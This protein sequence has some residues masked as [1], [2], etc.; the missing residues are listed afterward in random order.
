MR[1]G[2]RVRDSSRGKSFSERGI[3]EG[4]CLRRAGAPFSFN[5]SLGARGEKQELEEGSGESR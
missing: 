2:R 1:K 3:E 4:R 5:V